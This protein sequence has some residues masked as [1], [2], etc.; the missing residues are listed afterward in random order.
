M[1]SML[2]ISES[3]LSFGLD[4]HFLHRIVATKGGT[5][6]DTV[7]EHEVE[8]R[9]QHMAPY[10][11]SHANLGA[12]SI[13]FSPLC[14]PDVRHRHLK[15]SKGRGHSRNSP[16]NGSNFSEGPDVHQCLWI[17]KLRWFG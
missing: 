5:S 14:A 15:C 10:S 16:H 2:R 13:S 7:A 11:N 8:V 9:N 17:V 6:S 3:R 4:A 1:I 12:V